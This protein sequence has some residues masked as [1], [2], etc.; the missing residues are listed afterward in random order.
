MEYRF[1][2]CAAQVRIKINHVPAFGKWNPLQAWCFLEVR[3]HTVCRYSMGLLALVDHRYWFP[4]VNVGSPGRCHDA[5][6]YEW[7]G[8]ASAL[9]DNCSRWLL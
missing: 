2:A 7:S 4:Y 3:H 8:L 6:I 1:S 5:F 9:K